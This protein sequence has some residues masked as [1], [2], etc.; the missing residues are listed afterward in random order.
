[1]LGP[2]TGVGLVG[3]DQGRRLG[4]VPRSPRADA[5]GAWPVV[6]AMATERCASGAVNV[7]L[8]CDSAPRPAPVPLSRGVGAVCGLVA[9]LVR[10]HA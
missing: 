2:L 4:G 10:A 9:Q 1:M 7:S 6:L 3:S 5:C 8:P